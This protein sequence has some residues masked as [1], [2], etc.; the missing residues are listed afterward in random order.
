MPLK[1][2]SMIDAAYIRRSSEMQKENFSLDAQ[3]RAITEEYARR[4]RSA[5]VFYVDDER[6]ARG[7]QIA[8]RPAFKQLLEEIE[9]GRIRMVMVH[10][11]DRWPRTVMVTLQR[12]RI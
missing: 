12:F 10:S 11:P 9:A 3:K 8:K 5:P 4:G 7:E 1:E 6:S 2:S